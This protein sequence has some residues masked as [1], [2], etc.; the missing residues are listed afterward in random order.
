MLA[1]PENTGKKE[2][3]TSKES[4]AAATG[5]IS[6]TLPLIMLY[7]QISLPLPATEK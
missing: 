7:R 3:G 4:T 2:P 6:V 1:T 5:D